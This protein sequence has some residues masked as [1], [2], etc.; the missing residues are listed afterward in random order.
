[1]LRL[2]CALILVLLIATPSLG[3]QSLVGAYK[4]VSRVQD[5]QGS[6]SNEIMGKSPRGDLILTR[7]R[8][9]ALYTAEV[10]KPGT[11]VAEKAALYDTLTSWSGRYRVEGSKMIV[12]VAASWN[13]TWTGTDVVWNTQLSGN[14]LTLTSDPRP[15]GRDPSKTVVTRLV[16]EKIE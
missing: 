13:E 4:M 6:G 15:S 5:V 16:W 9:A 10:R 3:Q 14:R 8:V 2:I 12:S 11:S 7:T 1:M